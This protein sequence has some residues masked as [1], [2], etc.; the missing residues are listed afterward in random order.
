MTDPIDVLMPQFGMGMSQGRITTWH[1]RVGDS[2][3]RHQVIAEVEAEKV[4]V[5]IEAPASGQVI[6]ILVNAGE[7]AVV[8]QRLARIE[9][10]NQP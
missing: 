8:Q 5:E 7:S 4:D 9:P 3:S 6:E 1:V 10:S 2:V